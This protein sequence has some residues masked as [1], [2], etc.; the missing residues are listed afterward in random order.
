MRRNMLL[1]VV[2]IFP[3]L[4][5]ASQGEHVHSHQPMATAP[6]GGESINVVI[7]PEAR[8]RVVLV[9]P[10]PLP[11]PCGTTLAVPIRIINQG[12]VT[13]RLEAEP[14]GEVL[15]DDVVDFED[16]P[17]TGDPEEV[18][19]M[20]VTLVNAGQTD[21]T[22]AFRIPNGIPDLGGRNRINFLVSCL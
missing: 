7:N 13:G 12:Y 8:I 15:E 4:T 19:T 1:A 21:L 6:S 20:R 17:L 11:V 2:L 14:I 9:A 3:V 5:F 18:R 16:K 22:I 10:L